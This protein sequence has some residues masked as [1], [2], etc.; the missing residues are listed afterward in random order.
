MSD[1][2]NKN[3]KTLFG[4]VIPEV[5]MLLLGVAALAVFFLYYFVDWNIGSGQLELKKADFLSLFTVSTQGTDTQEGET[6]DIQ[7]NRLAQ[8]AMIPTG[9]SENIDSTLKFDNI[10]DSTAIK[11]SEEPNLNGNVTENSTKTGSSVSEYAGYV[12]NA[13]RAFNA[14]SAQNILFIG[15]SML[16]G[17]SKRFEDYAS[18]NS[19]KLN[20]VIWY[21]STSEIWANTDTLQYFLKKVDPS[22]VVI[23]L[24]SNELFVK[25][26]PRR[27]DY[28][29]KI[30]GKL[31]NLPFVWISPPN[32]KNDTGI[33]DA[34]ISVVGKG[35]YFDSRSLNL[36]RKSD[37][38]HPTEVAAAGWMDTIARWIQSPA[39]VNP[40]LMNYPE[41]P[42]KS[43]R[44]LTL[45]KPYTR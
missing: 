37:H 33:N 36:A 5:K 35:R 14:D 20:T 30:V 22:Y 32:W 2:T 21:S 9:L 45:L 34:I 13:I 23:C 10:A 39:C 19:H 38:A 6:Q 12:P 26:A 43:Q 8:D 42:S 16:E 17:L 29:K 28:I 1:E 18:R 41:R 31:G 25:D 24:G 15:D 44:K 27:K 40:L 3:K 7:G 11:V 4:K